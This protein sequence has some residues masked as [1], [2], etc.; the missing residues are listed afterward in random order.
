MMT[1]SL[2]ISIRE[3]GLVSARGGPP[4]LV[5]INAQLIK[6]IQTKAGGP[7]RAEPARQP[8]ADAQRPGHHRCLLA[9]RAPRAVPGDLKFQSGVP[10]G[11]KEKMAGGIL[12]A[13][14]SG[15]F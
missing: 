13:I 3:A 12:E 11:N 9:L 7:P 2:S 6:N 14:Y 15:I 10:S 1:W 5:W 8:D 4:A